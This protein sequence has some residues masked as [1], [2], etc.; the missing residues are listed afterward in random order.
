MMSISMLLS[1]IKCF[2]SEMRLKLNLVVM[3][4]SLRLLFLCTLFLCLSVCV[5][6][7]SFDLGCGF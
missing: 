2:E 3:R 1:F 4:E 6:V 7:I 5:S